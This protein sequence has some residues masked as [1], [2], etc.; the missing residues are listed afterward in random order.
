MEGYNYIHGTVNH[1]EF[2][3][4]PLTGID[5][6]AMEGM[7]AVMKK[8][9]APSLRATADG[10]QQYL[11]EWMWRRHYSGRLWAG[12][13]ESLS[14]VQYNNAGEHVF[15]EGTLRPLLFLLF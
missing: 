5:T 6:N 11:Y 13:L 15:A 7:W 4:D 8:N 10:I 14:M 9:I 2:F 3:K 12:I 1:S